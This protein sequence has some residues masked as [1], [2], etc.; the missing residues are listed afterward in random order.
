[1]NEDI[2]TVLLTNEQ[3]QKRIKEL[4]EQLC[5]DY[6]GKKVVMIVLLKGAAY[7]ATALSLAMN[8]PLRMEFM[9]VSSYGNGEKTTGN[10]AVRL[11][12][13]DD[14]AGKH[15]LLVDDIIDSGLT[16]ANIK[17]LLSTKHPASI[18]TVAMCDKRER[19]QNG[20]EADYVGFKVPDEF[21]VGFGLDY[22][23]D[24]RNLPYIGILKSSVYA[25]A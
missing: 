21:V 7:F 15:V 8:M 4:G 12:I 18:K 22:A 11:D 24:Y 23:G 5:K 17:Q 25:R 2:K 10:V 13:K 20:F 9:V 6:E 14:I 1:M 16:F 19:R 3:L